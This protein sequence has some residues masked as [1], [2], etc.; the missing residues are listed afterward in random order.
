[1][2]PKILIIDDEPDIR[3]LVN[4]ILTG[5]GYEV[6]LASTGGEGLQLLKEQAI[7]LVLLDI[8]LPDIAGWDVCRLIRSDPETADLPV[9]FFT[10]RN[11]ALENTPNEWELADSYLPKPFDPHE[12]I[13]TVEQFTL[14]RAS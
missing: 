4:L 12:L 2:L 3:A 6:V 11:R 5:A 9:L 14:A 13:T 8:M 7:D 10:V 1:M